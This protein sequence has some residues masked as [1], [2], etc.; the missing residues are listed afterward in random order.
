MCDLC[1]YL[2]VADMWCVTF[3]F[4]LAGSWHVT[5]DLF[6]YL[7][8]DMWRVIFVNFQVADMYRN[9]DQVQNQEASK[10]KDE[11]D[12]YWWRNTGTTLWRNPKTYYDWCRN[13]RTA[14]DGM[15]QWLRL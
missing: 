14:P 1:V 11:E 5:C 9:Q 8:V 12:Y 2:Q 10:K 15:M 13:T 3:V 4:V 6:V 7:Q